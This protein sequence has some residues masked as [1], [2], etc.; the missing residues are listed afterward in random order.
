MKQVSY[1][2]YF[3]ASYEIFKETVAFLVTGKSF[4]HWKDEVWFSF[5][6]SWKQE[7]PK[8]NRHLRTKGLCR[9]N[10]SS[11]LL[12]LSGTSCLPALGCG[13]WRNL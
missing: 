5:Y 3:D 13:S 1:R 6:C 9:T 2:L 12:S 11:Q 7:I 4:R 10:E 8:I